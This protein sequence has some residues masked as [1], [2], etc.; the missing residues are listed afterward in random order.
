M[1][2]YIKFLHLIDDWEGDYMG[3]NIVE[4]ILDKHLVEGELVAGSTAGI[5]IDRT[6]TQDSTGTMA[7]LQLEAMGIDKVKTRGLSPISTTTCYSRD[8]KM[9]MTTSIYKQ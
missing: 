6:L 1:K 3:R 5:R 9:L 7:Y 2:E 8:L 4:K